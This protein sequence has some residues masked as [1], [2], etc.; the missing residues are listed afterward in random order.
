MSVWGRLLRGLAAAPELP[1]EFAGRLE[2]AERLVTRGEL[3]GGGS[4]VLTNLGMWVPEGAE[5]RRI[6]WHLVSKA[7]WDRTALVITETVS[8]NMVGEAVLLSDLPPRRFAL[9]EPGKVPEVVR[10][11]VTSSIRSSQ[12]GELPGGGAW[13]VQR[14]VPGRDGLVLQVRPDPGTSPGALEAMVREVAL[15]LPRP[16]AQS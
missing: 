11:R 14:R 9:R 3:A 13:F 8:T 4:L 10:E 15:R 16:A 12:Y 6:G 2:P 1:R 5:S 7:V